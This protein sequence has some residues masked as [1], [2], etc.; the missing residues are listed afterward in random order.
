MFCQEDRYKPDFRITSLCVD[1]FACAEQREESAPES[2]ES[3]RAIECRVPESLRNQYA[4][5]RF[6][7]TPTPIR[8]VALLTTRVTSSCRKIGSR[9]RE[10]YRKYKKNTMFTSSCNIVGPCSRNRVGIGIFACAEPFLSP[11]PVQWTWSETLHRISEGFD[12]KYS[13]IFEIFR[14]IARG[15]SA[16]Q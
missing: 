3:L 12:Q 15:R 16:R 6:F 13:E 11:L 2:I 7:R 14:S 10:A 1:I 9:Q 8:K 4:I 5:M